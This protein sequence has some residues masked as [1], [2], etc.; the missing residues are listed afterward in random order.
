MELVKKSESIFRKMYKKDYSVN[1]S[2]N[3]SSIIN[4]LLDKEYNISEI[5][6]TESG[7]DVGER[8]YQ[9][10]YPVNVFLKM[11][12][13]IERSDITSYS[14]FLDS[15]DICCNNSEPQRYDNG[16]YEKAGNRARPDPRVKEVQPVR[17]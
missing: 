6:V 9:G 2:F 7:L 3:V 13:L 10:N 8:R 1:G 14:I 15:E 5:K 4:T 17:R 16:L 11:Y 12:D